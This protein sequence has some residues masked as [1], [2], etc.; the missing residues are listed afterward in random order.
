MI[1]LF[2]TSCMTDTINKFETFTVQIP[3]FFQS[4][5]TDKASPD[6]SVDFSNL[7][8][9]KEYNDNK[10]RIDAAEIYQINY[11]IDSLVLENGKVFDPEIDDM[12]FEYVAFKLK[13]A[14]PK[15]GKSQYSLDSTDFEPDPNSPLYIL[16]EFKNVNVKDYYRKSN[17]IIEVP[18][19]NAYAISEAMKNA[20]Y[21]YIYTE[22]SRIKTQTTPEV[23]LPYIRA[24]YDVIVRLKVKL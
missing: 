19:A 15:P 7:Y 14:V 22:Y 20:P 17:H 21:F 8:E 2:L 10:G 9:Y 13:F 18:E 6:T 4:Q 1:V 23:I 16:G 12:E 5:H 3:V 11:R 24:K